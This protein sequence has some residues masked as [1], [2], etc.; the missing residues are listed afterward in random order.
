MKYIEFREIIELF[1]HTS[2]HELKEETETPNVN[3]IFDSEGLSLFDDIVKNPF[4]LEGY[5]TPDATQE[6]IDYMIQR[7]NDDC[8]TLY[9][10]DTNKFFKYLMDITNSLLD[11]FK[12][13][14]IN[15]SPRNTAMN[16]M[17]RI[18]LRMG[19][20]DVENVEQF[21]KKQ[22]EFV[23]NKTFA[24]KNP[25]K[26]GS[27]YD[28]DVV[29]NTSIN[30]TWDESTRSMIF[31]IK[32]DDEEYELPHV[33]YDIDDNG[34]CYIFAVQSEQKKKSKTIE[35]KLYKLNKGIENPNVHPSKVYALMLFVEQLKQKYI[36][37]IIIPG[38]QVLSYRYHELLSKKIA[39]DLLEAQAKLFDRPT[40]E[41]Y[42]REYENMKKW[43]SRVHDKQDT[44]SYLKTEE[45]LNLVYRLTETDP[46]ME[47]TNELNLQG[48][49]INISIK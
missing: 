18:W 37:K 27:Y 45:L 26:V 10:K 43:Y 48:D 17:R 42:R 15:A 5:W 41:H 33:L 34:I 29:M 8:L 1:L 38:M 31:T 12:F 30:P 7:S 11:L 44:I 47:I 36:T 21:L 25:E 14:G 40:S 19:V 13:Y 20:E 2:I 3:F 28:Y 39:V 6:D 16:I 46:S 9:I 24:N 49:S 32:N 23:N 35:R 22:L 4:V